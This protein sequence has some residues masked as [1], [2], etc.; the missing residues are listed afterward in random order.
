M[1]N[2]VVREPTV[3][4]VQNELQHALY[5]LGALLDAV[6]EKQERASYY[7]RTFILAMVLSALALAVFLRV[8]AGGW[9]F[10]AGSALVCSL[11]GFISAQ[12]RQ[13]ILSGMLKKTWASC[14]ITALRVNGHRPVRSARGR[15]K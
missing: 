14:A 4:E 11:V 8:S 12:S 3:A 1:S 6:R 9:I 7:M 10:L 2:S 5:A 13:E 15:R